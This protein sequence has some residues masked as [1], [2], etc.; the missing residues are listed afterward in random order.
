[1]REPDCASGG[2]GIPATNRVGYDFGATR[3]DFFRSP[4]RDRINLEEPTEWEFNLIKRQTLTDEGL[5]EDR[6][7]RGAVPLPPSVSYPPS[8]PRH[9]PFH[10]TVPLITGT[11]DQGGTIKLQE[12]KEAK[13]CA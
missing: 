11:V 9:T 5:D 10:P 4:L 12:V 2:A 13:Q 1:M 3:C 7:H 8:C 6:K